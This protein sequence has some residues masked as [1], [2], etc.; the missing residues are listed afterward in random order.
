MFVH[1]RPVREPTL[2]A[3]VSCATD[4]AEAPAGAENWFVLANAPA[5]TD[6]D[7]SEYGDH[8]LARLGARVAGRIRARAE[9]SP[10]DLERETGAADGA[11][12]GD[13]P[14]GR[15]GTLRRPPNAVRG[16]R[17]L[18]RAGGTTHPGGGLPLV[19]LSG[20]IVAREIGPA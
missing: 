10:A 17:G 20:Q 14:H 8:L 12:Y 6:L 13:A 9:R 2:Y 18:W 15:L 11:I 3:S 19:M 5:R 1:R 4:P 16:T 7:W